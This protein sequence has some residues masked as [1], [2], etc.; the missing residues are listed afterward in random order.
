M[1]SQLMMHGHKNTSSSVSYVHYTRQCF[2]IKM[3]ILI[4]SMF[5]AIQR[6]LLRSSHL[7]KRTYEVL[8]EFLVTYGLYCAGRSQN[9]TL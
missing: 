3:Q 8:V 1:Y 2:K 7:F 6:L 9:S 4:K 5:L